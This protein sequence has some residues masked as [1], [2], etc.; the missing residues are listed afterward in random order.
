MGKSL[1][2][3][4]ALDE[5]ILDMIMDMIPVVRPELRRDLQT[6]LSRGSILPSSSVRQLFN[7][8]KSPNDCVWGPAADLV[9]K[10]PVRIKMI[11]ELFDLLTKPGIGDP[12]AAVSILRQLGPIPQEFLHELTDFLKSPQSSARNAAATILAGRESALPTNILQET[13]SLQDGPDTGKRDAAIQA[14]EKQPSLPTKPLEKAMHL[15]R[16]SGGDWAKS[17]LRFRGVLPGHILEE[18]VGLLES[19]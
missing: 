12:D 11:P 16:E 5:T 10:D 6:M 18:L 9:S 8:L 3:Q 1:F 17:I 2:R 13:T 4:V 14:L 7:M 15:F 19:S